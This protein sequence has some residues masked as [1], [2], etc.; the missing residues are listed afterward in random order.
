MEERQLAR[1]QQV[2]EPRNSSLERPARSTRSS[3]A[4][5]D[6]YRLPEVP[7][8]TREQELSLAREIEDLEIAHW[9]ALLSYAPALPSVAHA[10]AEHLP[11]PCPGLQALAGFGGTSKPLSAAPRKALATELREL[12]GERTG[13]REVDASVAALWRSEARARTY[14]SRLERA[15]T[16]QQ[17]AKSR[18]V[19]SNLRLVVRLSRAYDRGMLDRSDL[20]Q[21]GNIGLMR[22]VERFDHRRGLRFS[23]YASWW[24]RHYLNRAIA[25]KGRL[26]RI[27]VH[28]ADTRRRIRE[29][30]RKHHTRYGIKPSVAELASL[31]GLPEE[32]VEQ[33][34]QS[35]DAMP[36]SLDRPMFGD[37]ERTLHDVIGDPDQVSTDSDMVQTDRARAL[38]SSMQSLTSFEV[39]VL[40]F[41]Y[42]LDGDEA[43]TLREVGDKYNLS[44]ERIRQVQEAALAKL[45]VAFESEGV[46][47]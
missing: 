36:R 11:R 13:L 2:R 30:Q 31:T 35:N 19:A 22:A 5:T 46:V 15:R 9:C 41:R 45:R 33:V 21:E 24:I 4:H 16:A 23:T 6:N 12:D 14:V 40:R 42:G 47:A 38:E 28:A 17:R 43:L 29:A 20:I 1:S 10:V 37:S 25:D 44:R 8:L 27:P 26:V 32:V 18:F 39:A 34:L 7:L 3:G